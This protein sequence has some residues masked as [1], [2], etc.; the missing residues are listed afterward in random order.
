MWEYGICMKFNF[1]KDVLVG[2]WIIIVDDFI[3]WGIISCKIVWVLWEVG[4]I[5]VYMWI[6]F[7]LVIYFCFYGIDI[8][9]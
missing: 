4:V 9:S 1:F 2:K 8:D 7:L 3:V 6:F 5:E